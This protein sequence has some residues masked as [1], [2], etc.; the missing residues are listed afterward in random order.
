M[1][2]EGLRKGQSTSSARSARRAWCAGYVT[3]SFATIPWVGR[4]A[5]LTKGP[6]FALIF[7]GGGMKHR[8]QCKR[9]QPSPLDAI[10]D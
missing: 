3:R 6:I 10:H 8:E 4:G 5:L 2:N 1:P 9:K 7:R